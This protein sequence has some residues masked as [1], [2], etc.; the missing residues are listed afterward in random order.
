MLIKGAKYIESRFGSP[1]FVA[2]PDVDEV[3][4]HERVWKDAPVRVRTPAS[5]GKTVA[6]WSDSDDEDDTDSREATK[7][8]EKYDTPPAT[9][10]RP[11]TS[12]FSYIRE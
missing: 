6:D 10:A 7:I 3:V 2:G 4:Q 1:G 5:E 8:V 9:W 12:M 11:Y